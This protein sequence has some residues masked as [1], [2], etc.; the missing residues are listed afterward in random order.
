MPTERAGPG[1]NTIRVPSPLRDYTAGAGKVSASGNTVA[2]IL[3]HVERDHPGMRFRMIDEQ[4]RIRPHIRIFI[5]Q[6]EV[7]SLDE[8]VAPRDEIHLICALSGG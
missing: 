1:V 7:Q 6:R 5:N 2:E 4:D 3:S 8:A